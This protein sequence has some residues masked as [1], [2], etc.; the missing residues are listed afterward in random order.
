MTIRDGRKVV[1][2]ASVT[3]GGQ[4]T[5][6]V[7]NARLW[8]PEDPHL[9]NLTVSLKLGSRT[10]DKVESYFGMRKISLGKD[11]KGFTRLL[12]NNKPYFQ[13]GPLD[14]GFWPD[15]LYT[16]PTDEALRY[17]IE[18]T[19][20]LGFNMARKHVKIEPDRWYYWCDKLGLL[21]WQDM[22][23]G[24]KYIGQQRPGHHAHARNRPGSSSR[25]SRRWS[26]GAA[27]I[28]ASSCGCP[29]TKAGAS[30]T[31]PASSRWSRSSTRPGW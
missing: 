14:Q 30:G 3:A 21:V 22:P 31:P 16:A 2:T 27:T 23:S 28:P 7:K 24:D 25:N 18:M 5:M 17:D 19:K 13:F 9:Y 29:T 11:E 1:Y 12:L 26:R 6:P 15:G 4:I 8:S 10:I 20:K